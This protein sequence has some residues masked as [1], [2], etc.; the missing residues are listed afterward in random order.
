MIGL[1]ATTAGAVSINVNMYASSG[2]DQNPEDPTTLV[3]PAGGALHD[4][5]LMCCIVG[6]NT[7]K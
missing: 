3:G 2:G 6:Y 5:S 7:E 4:E 1:V